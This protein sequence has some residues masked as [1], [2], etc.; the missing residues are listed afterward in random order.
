MVLKLNEGDIST[1]FPAFMSEEAV[2]KK[3]IPEEGMETNNYF[4]IM[5][6]ILEAQAVLAEHELDKEEVVNL[7]SSLCNWMSEALEAVS[8]DIYPFFTNC[9]RVYMMVTDSSVNRR[10]DSL[11]A[12]IPFHFRTDLS[13]LQHTASSKR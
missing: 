4:R 1:R 11:R 10:E 9:F 5:C 13:V 6:R 8:V 12:I 3:L 7:A 2:E